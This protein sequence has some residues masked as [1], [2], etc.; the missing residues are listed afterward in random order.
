M[1]EKN[2]VL[3]I[4]IELVKG[5]K[6]KDEAI[7]VECNGK[8]YKIWACRYLLNQTLRQWHLTD[9][10]Y[11]ISKKAKILWNKLS[12]KNI[13][14]SHN[15]LVE[16]KNTEPI[17]VKIYKGAENKYEL[18]TLNYGDKFK[19]NSI[20]HEEHI[21]PI[22]VIIENLCKLNQLN[23]ENIENILD[24]IS[25]CKIL[26]EEDKILNK[27]HLKNKR[28]CDVNYVLNNLYKNMGIEVIKIN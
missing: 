6:S 25:I 11:Y 17:E 1:E 9:D 21:I 19:F 3:D 27:N 28:P 12:N 7:E 14:H 15:K 5:L 22:S 10:K 16:C 20:F 18:K 4:I 26:K 8:T 2:V 13:I 23:Y 24:K